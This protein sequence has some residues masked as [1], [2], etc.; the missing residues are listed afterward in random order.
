MRK[1]VIVLDHTRGDQNFFKFGEPIIFVEL[2]HFSEE[3]LKLKDRL[4]HTSLHKCRTTHASEATLEPY[5]II[6]ELYV[7]LYATASMQIQAGRLKNI[8]T[9]KQKKS[10]S[11]F[12]FLKEVFFFIPA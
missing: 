2:V 7:N 6:F 8:N 12:F 4:D 1:K 5:R 11:D 3:N 10:D 9:G